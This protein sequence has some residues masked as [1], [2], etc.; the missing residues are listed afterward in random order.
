M[1]SYFT[2]LRCSNNSFEIGN[3]RTTGAGL[4]RF[5]GSQNQKFADIIRDNCGYTEFFKRGRR[6]DGNI[7]DLIT[8]D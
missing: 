6:K 7:I 8:G 2:G 3:I 1:L 4:S 5:C